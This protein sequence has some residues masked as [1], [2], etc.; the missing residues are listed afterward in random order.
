MTWDGKDRRDE[1][2]IH[3]SLGRIEEAIASAAEDLSEIKKQ[4]GKRLHSLEM[5]RSWLTG[6][7]A[8][9][10]AAVAWAI[11]TIKG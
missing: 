1:N 4:Y 5:S 10:S 11:S 8:V 6:A 7:A 2:E 9:V 3:H